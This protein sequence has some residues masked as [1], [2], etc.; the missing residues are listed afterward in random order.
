MNVDYDALD[1]IFRIQDI[2]GLIALGV[3]DNEYE[4]EVEKIFV[5]LEALPREEATVP[6]LVEV[7]EG[8]YKQMFGWSDEDMRRRRP[9]FEEIAIKVM[10]Y[11]G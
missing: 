4:P 5:A 6:K 11:F 3:P 8:V 1:E 9:H 2:E 7:F 10:S